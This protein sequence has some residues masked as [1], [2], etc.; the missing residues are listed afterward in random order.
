V[1][2]FFDSGL[3]PGLREIYVA[4]CERLN[5]ETC[6]QQ[7]A[8]FRALI[9]ATAWLRREAEMAEPE[10]CEACG[11]PMVTVCPT[12]LK[13]GHDE[14]SATGAR[15]VLRVWAN[16]RVLRGLDVTWYGDG[17]RLRAESRPDK[18]PGMWLVSRSGYPAYES[19]ETERWVLD[20][21]AESDAVGIE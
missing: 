3:V 1:K 6:E 15:A 20:A 19:Y 4:A 5:L 18:S 11:E 8:I 17:R 10:E 2:F 16:Q 21:I 12:S 14:R 7:E 9:D 13:D